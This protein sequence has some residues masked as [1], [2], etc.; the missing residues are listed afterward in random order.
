MDTAGIRTTMGSLVHAERVPEA[1]ALIVQRLRAAGAIVI[2]KT[3]TPEFGA[4]SHTF[5]EVFGATR[6]P[7]DLGR[8]AGGSSGGAAAALA[9]GMIPLADGSDLGGSVRNPAS[10]CSVVGLRPSPGRV[11]STRPGNA[12]DPMSL[13]GPMAR[14]VDDAALL[15][16]A[17][18][19]PDPRAP[20]SID[21]DPAPLRR[22][23]AAARWRAPGSPGARRSTASRSSPRSARR[24]RPARE[25]L[26]ER[27]RRGG[28][29]GAR[30]GRRRSRL[31]DLPRARILRRPPGGSPRAP[32][33]GQARGARRRRARRGARPASRSRPRRRCGRGCSAA[34]VALLARVRALALPTVQLAPFPVDWRHPERV[35]GVEM[36]RYY[37]WMRSCTRISATT[38]PALSLPAG[39]TADR[40]AGRAAAGRPPPRR[41]RPARLRGRRSK[42]PSA[43]PPGARR[44]SRAQMVSGQVEQG[45]GVGAEDRGALGGAEAGERDSTWAMVAAGSYQ[46][47][48]EP[49]QD[50]VGADG[51]DQPDQ[52]ARRWAR[53]GR[54]SRRRSPRGRTGPPG[55]RRR[56]QPSRRQAAPPRWAR[57]SGRSG[58]RSS[59]GAK[60]AGQRPAGAVA[61]GAAVGDDRQPA[62]GAGG[63]GRAE[64]RFAGV[65][66]EPDR[67]QL[68]AAGAALVGHLGDVG[69]GLARR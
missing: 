28:R 45:G 66:A 69:A 61:V 40:P 1:D 12:W 22:A 2:G 3:N 54:R 23:A 11:A 24:W 31:R 59:T 7:W 62:L 56:T 19:G 44:C 55:R 38:L 16:A 48:S 42:P 29:A 8:S 9:A 37:T 33:P 65:G 39:F 41:A 10:F 6:N 57:T 50:A 15:L 63:E 34:P 51:A 52:L 27:R 43:P 49:M 30:P 35:A 26:L 36:E 46:G 13:L 58:W 64:R 25:R 67:V 18:A 14:G 5:N 4:G 17:I 68:E 53:A 47:K 60:A 21:E 20:I 32:G